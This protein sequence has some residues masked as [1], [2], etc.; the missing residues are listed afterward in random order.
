VPAWLTKDVAWFDGAVLLG[1]LEEPGRVRVLPWTAAAS[2]LER[3][4]QLLESEIG[5]DE[6]DQLQQLEDRYFRV[7]AEPIRRLTFHKS[8]LMHLGVREAEDVVVVRLPDSLEI[9]SPS[10]R[11]LRLALRHPALAGLP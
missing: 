4:S 6:L 8:T 3:R 7:P 9:W 5:A 10:Y 2:V 1:V 11:E